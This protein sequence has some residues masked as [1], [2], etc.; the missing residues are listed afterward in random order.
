MF[1]NGI[2]ADSIF[3]PNYAQHAAI[4]HGCQQMSGRA[5]QTAPII[6]DTTVRKMGIH[7]ARVDL[8]VFASQIQ[9]DAA[10]VSCAQQA[11]LE[12]FGGHI[13]LRAGMHQRLK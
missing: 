7:F 9:H 13:D 3:A 5:G 2:D 1:V 12:A 10:R 11:I 8:T 4:M 6:L